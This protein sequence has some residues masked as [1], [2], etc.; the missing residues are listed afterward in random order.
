MESA[1]MCTDV[2]DCGFHFFFLQEILCRC[3]ILKYMDLFM[4]IK[5]SGRDAHFAHNVRIRQEVR[6]F[7][8]FLTQNFE[9]SILKIMNAMI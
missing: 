7:T 9:K 4:K 6:F 8:F 2:S 5:I 3:E 1:G